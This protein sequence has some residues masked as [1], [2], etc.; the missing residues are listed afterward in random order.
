MIYYPYSENWSPE[1]KIN[2]AVTH[3]PLVTEQWN[4]GALY[5]QQ[6]GYVNTVYVDDDYAFGNPTYIVTYDD[7]LQQSDFE[8]GNLPFEAKNYAVS[9]SDRNYNPVTYRNQVQSIPFPQNPNCR[10]ELRIRDGRWTLLRESFGIFEGGIEFA[11][12]MTIDVSQVNIPGQPNSPT[13]LVRRDA[14]GWGYVGVR[15]NAIREMKKDEKKFVH[16]GIYISY[17]CEGDPDKMLFIYEYDR[18]NLFS[19][20]SLQ[21][22]KAVAAAANLISDPNQRERVAAFANQGIQPLVQALLNGTTQSSIVHYSLLGANAVIANQRIPTSGIRPSLIN[23]HR[24]YGSS[25]ACVTL[26]VD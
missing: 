5:N 7:G 25:N 22:S 6:G 15:R 2:Y 16:L 12:A 9:V 26:V 21:W 4:Y 10:K 1:M 18:P 20:N 11:A 14:H 23:G 24:P 13:I 8:S 3:H 17:W 19:T